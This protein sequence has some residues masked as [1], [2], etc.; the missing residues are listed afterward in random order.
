[1]N[2]IKENI[3]KEIEQI[4][5]Y[6]IPSSDS[7][8]ASSWLNIIPENK[9][10]KNQNI[11]NAKAFLSSL[12]NLGYIKGNQNGE[13]YVPTKKYLNSGLFEVKENYRTSSNNELIQT[14][15]ILFTTKGQDELKPIVLKLIDIKNFI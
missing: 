14:C 4:R 12:L 6:S 8:T 5:E 3:M 15:T 9:N 2:N 13:G 10:I 11:I 1:M 7:L